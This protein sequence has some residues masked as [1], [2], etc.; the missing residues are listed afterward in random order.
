MGSSLII[1][2]PEKH[3]MKTSTLIA[4][5]KQIEAALGVTKSGTVIE[6]TDEI[7]AAAEGCRTK[8][9]AGRSRDCAI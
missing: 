6:V 3:I 2:E 4:I 8:K 9:A 5:A 7:K 1:R